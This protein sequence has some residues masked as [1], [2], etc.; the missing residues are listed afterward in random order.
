MS[1]VFIGVGHGGTDPGA[2]GFLVEKDINLKM[3]RACYNYL[4]ERG[5]EAKLSRETDESERLSSKIAECNAYNADLAMDVHNNAGRGDGFE[6]F[7]SVVGGTGR[8]LAQNIEAEIKKIGQN[9]RGIKTKKNS[10]GSDYFGFI[11]QTNCPAV[12]CEGV[13]VDNKKDAEQADTDAECRA[14]GEAYARGV[15]KTLGLPDSSTGFLVKVTTGALNI[16]SGAGTA[17]PVV[18][19]IRDKGVYTILETKTVDGLSWGRL[20]SGAGWICLLYTRGL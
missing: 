19:V 15:L 2:V 6:V 4:I 11:R 14:F 5:V 8:L 12:I 17:N 7:H 20:K 9:S 10:R 18:G 3:A 16:R 1:R 13:F